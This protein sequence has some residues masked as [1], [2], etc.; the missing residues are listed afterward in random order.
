MKLV[1]FTDTHNTPWFKKC[2]TC[3]RQVPD[4]IFIH[5]GDIAA[6]DT[7]QYL[8]HKKRYGD[9]W[10]YKKGKLDHAEQKDIIWFDQLNTN[11]WNSQIDVLE[12]ASVKL[13]LCLG[14][15]DQAY[16]EWYPWL[17][18]SAFLTK[19]TH[20]HLQQ[21]EN[22]HVLYLPYD[23]GLISD[24]IIERLSGLN[25]L[26][27]FAHC[28]PMPDGKKYYVDLYQNLASIASKVRN[29]TFVHGHMHADNTYSYR[30]SALPNVE[31]MTLKAVDSNDGIGAFNHLLVI[32]TQTGKCTVFDTEN[33]EQK[34]QPLPEQYLLKD[35]HWNTFK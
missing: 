3:A 33:K 27:I 2:L 14:N 19:I 15:S 29:I 8:A 18:S 12:S 23:S 35:V 13:T 34:L 7:A 22:L 16:L 9:V 4:G 5:L 20:I 6:V 31:I 30:L 26:F 11:G 24:K 21:Y 1:V 28:P 25:Q 32:D 17:K 10:K